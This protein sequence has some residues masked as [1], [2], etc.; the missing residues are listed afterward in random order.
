M[1]LMSSGYRSDI[2]TSSSPVLQ[3]VKDKGR[4][5]CA[6]VLQGSAG[7]SRHSPKNP[8]VRTKGGRASTAPHSPSPSSV[9]SR[10]ENPPWN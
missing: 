1:A 5:S 4:G 3:P 7:C 8:Q 10:L 2:F 6:E 9:H